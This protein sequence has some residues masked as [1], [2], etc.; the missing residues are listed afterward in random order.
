MKQVFATYFLYNSIFIE[1]KLDSDHFGTE[2]KREILNIAII[3]FIVIRAYM[4]NGAD[5]IK[6][7]NHL[8]AV[9]PKNLITLC[10]DTLQDI[11]ALD[12]DVDKHLPKE[13]Y[14]FDRLGK[15]YY[16]KSQTFFHNFELVHAD[17]YFSLTMYTVETMLL[18]DQ[19]KYD[20]QKAKELIAA[21][22]YEPEVLNVLKIF[23]NQE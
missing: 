21:H 11:S 5:M 14:Y 18:L 8:R 6:T 1:Q 12:L 19:S 23:E 9:A 2:E 17:E 16:Q 20:I 7:Q 13:L 4:E 22:E 3:S 15:F 10:L